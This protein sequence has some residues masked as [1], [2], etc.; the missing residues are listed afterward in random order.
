MNPPRLFEIDDSTRTR[1]NGAKLK[2]RQ[3]HSDC[4]KLFFTNDVVRDWNK[5]PP[6]LVKWNTIAWF[7]NKLD[8]LHLN[9]HYKGQFQRHGG[10]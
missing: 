7:Q 10:T 2:C 6:S 3:V 1:H 4:T 9:V 5:L 8:L